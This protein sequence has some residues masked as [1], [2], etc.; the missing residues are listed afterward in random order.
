[1]QQYWLF[2]LIIDTYRVTWVTHHTCTICIMLILLHI[3]VG[4]SQYWEIEITSNTVLF[5]CLFDQLNITSITN[6]VLHLQTILFNKFLL[7]VSAFNI[8]FS[9]E[10]FRNYIPA[11]WKPANVPLSWFFI[12]IAVFSLKIWAKFDQLLSCWASN[13]CFLDF[14]SI[15]C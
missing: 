11:Q 3:K 12:F 13:N 4:F 8:P 9:D 15:I 14:T 7:N 5:V 6:I 10:N 1:M 2:T